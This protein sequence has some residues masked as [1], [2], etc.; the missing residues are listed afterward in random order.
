[1][2]DKFIASDAAE[3]K[4]V[5]TAKVLLGDSTTTKDAVYQIYARKLI[6][7]V[8]DYCHREDF[9]AALVYTC[10]DLLVK[11]AND[12][13]DETRGLKSVKMDDTQFDFA[14]SDVSSGSQAD[15]DFET[16]RPKL[17]LYRK[18]GGWG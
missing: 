10:A 17:N 9:P 11:R 13:Q 6:S 18:I 2:D 16:I 12:A 15:A 3:T 5:D 1:M 8:L 7:D 14:N 4:I